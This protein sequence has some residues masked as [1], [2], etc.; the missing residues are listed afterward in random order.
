MAWNK[1]KKEKELHYVS[2]YDGFKKYF[3]L[4]KKRSPD[5]MLFCT[6]DPDEWFITVVV[7]KKKSGLVKDSYYVIRKDLD[8]Y[9][10]F[11]KE[12]IGFDVQEDL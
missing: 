6:D 11:A 10:K 3:R 12:V 5:A 1:A 7:H 4:T 9:V 2:E 8:E